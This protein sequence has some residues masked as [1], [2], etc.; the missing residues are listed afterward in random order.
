MEKLNYTKK[1][2][3]NH[4][5]D[6]NYVT[7]LLYFDGPLLS[8]YTNNK[9]QKLLFYWVDVDD[10]FNRWLV[11]EINPSD[12]IK[13]LNKNISLYSLITS[14]VNSLYKVDIDNNIKFNNIELI[15][16]DKLP[17]NYLPLKDSYFMESDVLENVENVILKCKTLQPNNQTTNYIPKY[18]FQDYGQF[19]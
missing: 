4:F 19:V 15:D 18:S 8:L 17:E 11:R 5:G 14:K 12:V 13:Y 7:D 9:G 16:I 10:D 6:I 2:A 1:V 3:D